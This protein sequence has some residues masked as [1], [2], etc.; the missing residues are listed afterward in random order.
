M[1]EIFHTEDPQPTSRR[2]GGFY[3]KLEDLELAVSLLDF[4][5]F[6]GPEH[7]QRGYFMVPKTSDE[8]Q[9]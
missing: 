5:V 8:D 7:P 6:V 2:V 4:D 9:S 1:G 3:A